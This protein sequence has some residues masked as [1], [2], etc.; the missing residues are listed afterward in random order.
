MRSS[1]FSNCLVV[2][3]KA[4]STFFL[5]AFNASYLVGLTSFSISSNS[6]SIVSALG[7]SL[8]IRSNNSQFFASSRL[9]DLWIILLSSSV[10]FICPCVLSKISSAICS[11]VLPTLLSRIN[12]A[13][14][15][16]ISWLIAS[17]NVAPVCSTSAFS[18]SSIELYC[19]FSKA[20]SP[21][22]LYRWCSL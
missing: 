3:V 9:V 22:A 15:L 2:S 1:A 4:A 14:A 18:N 6:V 11:L 5:S 20:I 10:S 17:L 7:S 13:F 21:N 12:S 19:V 16:F 8:R